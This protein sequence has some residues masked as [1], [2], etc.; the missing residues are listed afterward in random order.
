MSLQ[1]LTITAASAIV[2]SWP[3]LA[4]AN[5]SL[6]LGPYRVG[7]SNAEASR[8]GMTQCKESSWLIECRARIE[9][10]GKERALHL[11]FDASRKRLVEVSLDVVG[12]SWSVQTARQ[13][14]S[15]LKAD[16]CEPSLE[17]TSIFAV[18]CYRPPDQVRRVLWGVNHY[19][20]SV[21]AQD[22]QAL[23]WFQKRRNLAT[24][25][26]KERAFERGR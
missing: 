6:S 22:G 15:E 7:M 11:R 25:E 13:I 8:L 20:V 3:L 14:L 1:F 16:Q 9:V 10:L 26:Q 5:A 21:R 4:V 19:S 17:E 24:R 23:A 18:V 2:L 12:P